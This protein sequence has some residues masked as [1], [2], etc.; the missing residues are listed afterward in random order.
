VSTFGNVLLKTQ[1]V[2]F[3]GKGP[4]IGFAAQAWNFFWLKMVPIACRSLVEEC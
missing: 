4:R 2:V 3:D 1:F